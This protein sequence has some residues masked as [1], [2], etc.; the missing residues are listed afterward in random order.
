MDQPGNILQGQ[1]KNGPEGISKITDAVTL[2]IDIEW[3][4]LGAEQFQ[5]GSICRT[6]VLFAWQNLKALLAAFQH[7]TSLMFHF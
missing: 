1:W 2:I 7:S 6:L 3:K 5:M 4:G